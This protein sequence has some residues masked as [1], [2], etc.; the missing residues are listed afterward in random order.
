MEIF[1][2]TTSHVHNVPLYMHLVRSIVECVFL[3]IGVH[4]MNLLTFNRQK[5]P[6]HSGV[7]GRP[8]KVTANLPVPAQKAES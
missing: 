6:S 3:I 1:L 4:V 2:L 8:V 7:P 5:E